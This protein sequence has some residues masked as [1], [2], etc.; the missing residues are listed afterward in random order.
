VRPLATLARCAVAGLVV[1]AGLAIAAPSALLA[2]LAL[3]IAGVLYV[4]VLAL[5]GEF[6]ADDIESLRASVWR[7][8]RA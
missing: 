1:G 4:V 5:L 6:S 3:L 7:T 8:Q 2:P